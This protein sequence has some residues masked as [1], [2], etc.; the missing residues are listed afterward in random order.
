MLPYEEHPSYHKFPEETV[1]CTLL[2][3]EAEQKQEVV[4]A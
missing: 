3:T 2:E 1:S 4:Q